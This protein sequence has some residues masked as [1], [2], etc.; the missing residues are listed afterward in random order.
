[1]HT[2]QGKEDQGDWVFEEADKSSQ[3]AGE[4]KED[5]PSF[6]PLSSSTELHN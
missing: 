3:A 5:N 4:F 1:M 2:L 6:K